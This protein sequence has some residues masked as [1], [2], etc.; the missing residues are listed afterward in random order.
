[1]NSETASTEPSSST[2]SDG[3]WSYPPDT[4]LAEE[5]FRD[6][7]KKT[8]LPEERL[9]FAVLE[10]ALESFQEHCAARHGPRRR[11]FQNTERWF[12]TPSSRS[13]FDFESLCSVLG[14]DPGYIRKG[15]IQWRERKLSKIPPAPL[16]TTQ[17]KPGR[18]AG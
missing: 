1:M 3:Y 6:H 11:L 18:A 9:M 4:L 17:S 16:V 10:D 15:L 12:F 2:A 8:L 5:F 13:V 14:F 7:R